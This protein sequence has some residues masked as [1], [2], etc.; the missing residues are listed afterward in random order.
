MRQN[1]RR[2]AINRNNRSRLRT[3][4]K[5]LHAALESGDQQEL[6]S[7]LPATISRIDKAIQEGVLHRNAAARYK[8][9]LTSRA[10]QLLAK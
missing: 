10:N 9:R 8:S 6:D 1:E 3:S 7:L 5:K 4:I 2:R